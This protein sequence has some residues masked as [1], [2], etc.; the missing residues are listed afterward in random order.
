MDASL[1]PI[2]PLFSDRA[3]PRGPAV[4]GQFY[5]AWGVGWGGCLRHLPPS[6]ASHVLWDSAHLSDAVVIVLIFLS[7]GARRAPEQQ[8]RP[9]ILVSGCFI[10][11]VSDLLFQAGGGWVEVESCK[12][13]EW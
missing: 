5:L 4:K 9:Q 6:A 12:S 13:H 3:E 11:S 7:A 2:F 8:D 1:F 10:M